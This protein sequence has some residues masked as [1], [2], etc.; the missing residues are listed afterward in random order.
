MTLVVGNDRKAERNSSYR[1]P[2]RNVSRHRNYYSQPKTKEDYPLN[3]KVTVKI[4]Q[5][6]MCGMGSGSSAVKQKLSIESHVSS[7][8]DSQKRESSYFIP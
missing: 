5:R 7:D 4:K 6:E 8:P 1:V 3:W 2:Q